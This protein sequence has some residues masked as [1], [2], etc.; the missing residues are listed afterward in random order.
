MAPTKFPTEPASFQVAIV[1]ALPR[2]ADAVTLLFDEIWTKTHDDGQGSDRN[3]YAT[4]RIAQHKVVLATLPGMGTI[5]AARSTVKLTAK[6]TGLRLALLVG[7][8]GGSPRITNTNAFLGDVVMSK[9]ILQYDFGK[10][11]PY[12]FVVRRSV[13]DSLGRP[14]K[15]IRS[16]LAAFETE[17]VDQRLKRAA[18]GHLGHLQNIAKKDQR[19]ADYQYPGAAKDKLYPSK[20]H[21]KHRRSC[22]ECTNDPNAICNAATKS[23][24]IEL[25]C[26]PSQL[27]ARRRTANPPAGADF[28]PQLFIGRVG[29]GNSVVK[30][31]LH[32]D[33][34]AADHGIIAFEIEGAGVWDH[35]PCIVV[36]GICDYADS[37]KNKDWQ[38]FASATAASVAKAIVERYALDE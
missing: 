16:L 37:H 5:N 18:T 35:V 24:C 20:Y 6:Y 31:A 25:G 34:I 17:L 10:Q 21:H 15:E 4:G 36:K 1:C 2:E 11:Y 12:H 28:V 26:D 30:S 14:N 22:S 9:S 38:D 27:V 32:R 3:T 7:I 19:Y 33:R 8:C 23:S 13:E 29:S